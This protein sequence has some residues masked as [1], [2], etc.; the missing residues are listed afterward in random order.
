MI[1]I[2]LFIV[3]VYGIE[4]KRRHWGAVAVGLYLGAC[5]WRGE[6]MNEV[7]FRLTEFSSLWNTPGHNTSYQ[8]FIGLNMEI[9]S[10]FL[11]LGVVIANFLC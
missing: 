7:I 4:V 9:Y 1:P 8:I 2:L 5:D 6:I 10:M 3:H 11:V